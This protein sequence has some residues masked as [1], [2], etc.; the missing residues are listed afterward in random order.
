MKDQPVVERSRLTIFS[1]SLH[2]TRLGFLRAVDSREL[3]Y[4]TKAVCDAFNCGYE[5]YPFATLVQRPAEENQGC[6]YLNLAR[7]NDRE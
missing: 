2:L 7:A 5:K 3:F 6:I 4:I 1:G